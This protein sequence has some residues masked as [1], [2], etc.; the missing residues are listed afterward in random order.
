MSWY[1]T[2]Y[3]GIEKEQAR[4]EKM[5]GPPRFYVKEG[6]SKEVVFIDDEILCIYEHNPK[7][8][9]SYRNWLTCVQGI[10]DDVVCCQKLGPDSRYYCGYLTVVDCT[11]WTDQRGNSHE[12][13]MKMVQ[14]KMKTMKRFRRKKEDRGALA[15]LLF[16]ATREDKLSPSCGDEWEFQREADMEKLFELVSYK[17][18]KLS[19]LWSEAEADEKIMDRVTRTFQ[20]EPDSEGV[21]PR[22]VPAINYYEVLKPMEPAELRQYLGSVEIEPRNNSSFG[23][24]KASTVREDEIPF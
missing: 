11:A 6:T 10:H 21:L 16:R 12:Y 4:Q 3:D 20:I 24:Q 1:S 2:G 17:G 7:I 18:K 14:A 13:E 15:G 22:R 9:G 23:T 8:G 5:Y 19:V